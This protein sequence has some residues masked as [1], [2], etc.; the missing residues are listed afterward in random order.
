VR[1]CLKDIGKIIIKQHSGVLRG[2]RM[3]DS[4]EEIVMSYRRRRHPFGLLGV[5]ASLTE[6]LTNYVVDAK[7]EEAGLPSEHRQ[8]EKSLTGGGMD[9]AMEYQRDLERQKEMREST[10]Q[11]IRET[12][13]TGGDVEMSDISCGMT[14]PPK[15]GRA[16]STM[17]D[18]AF[19]DAFD[20]LKEE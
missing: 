11:E 6:S 18:I 5:L 14:M 9:F 2:K 19:D 15:A 16:P 12:Y 10:E 3:P 8:Y 17:D 20:K 1:Y 4:Q 7:R 13:V